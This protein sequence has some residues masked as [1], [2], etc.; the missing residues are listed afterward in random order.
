MKVE[1]CENCH[2]FDSDRYSKC[3]HCTG[4]QDLKYPINNDSNIISPVYASPEM[5]RRTKSDLS[6]NAEDGNETSDTVRVPELIGK[7]SRPMLIR[8]STEEIIT[9][10]EPVFLIGRGDRVDYSIEN[11]S[12]A[13]VHA[14]ILIRNGCVY[15]AD[16]MAVNHTFVNGK[17]LNKFEEVQLSDGDIIAFAN[18]EY[19]FRIPKPSVE[20]EYPF[21]NESND[22]LLDIYLTT[23]VYASPGNPFK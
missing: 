12:V 17:M 21:N 4:R 7:N 20:K 2:F 15:V 18:E 1:R 3:P 19:I 16:R 13:R 11:N 9:I 10:G 8:R 14:A 22:D 6:S 23:E 5:M